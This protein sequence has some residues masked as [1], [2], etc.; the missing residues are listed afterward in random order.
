MLS[1]VTCCALGGALLFAVVAKDLALPRE[2]LTTGVY[3]VSAE[4]VEVTIAVNSTCHASPPLERGTVV[5]VIKVERVNDFRRIRGRILYPSVWKHWVNLSIIPDAW[6]D[7]ENLDTGFRWVQQSPPLPG[8]AVPLH[9]KRIKESCDC[10][11]VILAAFLTGLTD[12]QRGYYT[13]PHLQYMRQFCLSLLNHTRQPDSGIEAV[14]LHNEL[15]KAFVRRHTRNGGGSSISFLKV[16]LTKYPPG[17]PN[18]VRFFIYRDL[19]LEHPEWDTV[20]LTDLSDVS[21]RHNPCQI[22]F[23]SGPEYLYVGSETKLFRPSWFI[24]RSFESIGGRYLRWYKR[25]PRNAELNLNTGVI[26]GKHQVLFAFLNELVATLSTTHKGMAYDMAALNWVLRT[27]YNKTADVITGFPLH[28]EFKMFEE[29]R[30]DVY[31]V[32]K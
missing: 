16:D 13:T 31:F 4:Q 9:C 20:F 10:R 11:S 12:P 26:G 25:R 30:G 5:S 24:E 19:L 32:H 17:S 21:V 14:V 6:I 2:V 8:K 23:C 27:K 28:S 22:V 1:L 7:L 3:R 15:D 29:G 18:D